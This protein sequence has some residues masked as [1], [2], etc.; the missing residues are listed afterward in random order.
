MEI[1]LAC[2]VPDA[3]DRGWFETK[4]NRR[5]LTLY[6]EI[7][8]R[9]EFANRRTTYVFENRQKSKKKL[10]TKNKIKLSSGGLAAQYFYI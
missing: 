5:V 3:E 2:A 1:P 7:F 10:R 4:L 8:V 9:G 6:T